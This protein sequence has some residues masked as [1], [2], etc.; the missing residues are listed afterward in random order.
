[1]PRRALG[2]GGSVPYFIQ[3]FSELSSCQAACLDYGRSLD[4]VS[5][6]LQ[7]HE[8]FEEFKEFKREQVYEIA[9]LQSLEWT[10]DTDSVLEKFCYSKIV[11]SMLWSRADQVFAAT[12]SRGAV[13]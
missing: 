11:I 8:E 4:P 5:T 1:M 7:W 13:K 2:F 12:D 3:P 10:D 9:D 6:M